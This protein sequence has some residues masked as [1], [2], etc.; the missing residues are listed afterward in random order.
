ML[1]FLAG[2]EMHCQNAVSVLIDRLPRLYQAWTVS[3]LNKEIIQYLLQNLY[4]GESPEV[5]D[6]LSSLL[7][8][9]VDTKSQG[10]IDEDQFVTWVQNLPQETVRS[11]L[12][13]P[14]IPPEITFSTQPQPSQRQTVAPTEK[15]WRV[16]D[17]QLLRLASEVS[18][19]R[20][21][22]KLLANNLGFLE[23]DCQMFQSRHVETKRQILEM[24]QVWRTKEAQAVQTQSLQEALRDTGN[25]DISTEVFQLN[26]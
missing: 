3:T 4:P 24:L 21:D 22:W 5:I 18:R 26:F 8:Q 11:V 16:A 23:R 13:F 7:L 2:I 9:E 10:Y 14:L 25:A 19:R 20:R 6:Q 17:E 1:V 15:S 12:H